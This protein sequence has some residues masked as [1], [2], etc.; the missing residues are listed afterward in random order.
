MVSKF[1]VS[2]LTLAV[3]V[4]FISAVGQAAVKWKIMDEIPGV[5][6]APYIDRALLDARFDSAKLACD[7][8]AI[9]VYNSYFLGNPIYGAVP[10]IA[11]GKPIRVSWLLAPALVCESYYTDYIKSPITGQFRAEASGSVTIAEPI[12]S[13]G[14]ELDKTGEICVKIDSKNM[15]TPPEE[16]CVGNPINVA[17]G[18]KFQYETDYSSNT[19][20]GLS[21]SRYYNSIDGVWR[22]N[23]SSLIRFYNGKISLVEADGRESLFTLQGEIAIPER[24]NESAT[25]AKK[26]NYWIYTSPEGQRSSFDATSGRLVEQFSP[27]RGRFIL[28]YNSGYVKVT[29]QKGQ[30]LSFSEDVSHQPLTFNAADLNIKYNYNANKSLIQV[31]RSRGKQTE[32]R[33][34]HYEDARNTSLLTGITDERGVRFATW[35]YDTKGRAISSEHAGGAG[36][37]QIAYND[38]GSSI[39]TNELGKQTTYKYVEIDGV[40]RLSELVGEPS[41]NCPASN[42]KYSYD[43]NGRL[44]YRVDAK[45]LV[46][47]YEYNSQGLE[48]K[49]IEAAGT[50]EQRIITTQWHSEFPVP[51]KITDDIRSTTYYYDSEGRLMAEVQAPNNVPVSPSPGTPITLPPRPN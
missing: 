15:G 29:D 39:V 25:M 21:F 6:P 42:S 24:Q 26:D 4:T 7:A 32:A 37:T 8:W 33:N 3:F 22:H 47:T 9:G 38:D 46:T 34:F 28:S 51:I 23:Y 20:N 48:S 1:A 16:S 49:R 27:Q 43:E 36:R 35:T 5:I 11:N 18:N 40:K 2:N 44:R 12:C 14:K 13:E 30:S 17:I 41:P 45:G 10:N 19:V 31:V 50:P